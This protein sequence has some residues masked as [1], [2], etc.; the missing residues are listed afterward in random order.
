MRALLVCLVAVTHSAAFAPAVV[1][2]VAVG[3]RRTVS[4]SSSPVDVVWKQQQ[5]A[6]VCWPSSSLRASTTADAASAE[7]PE[8]QGGGG[9]ATITQYVVATS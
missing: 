9:S 7:E 6:S 3:P 5:Q 2:T 4:V 8:P 1:R